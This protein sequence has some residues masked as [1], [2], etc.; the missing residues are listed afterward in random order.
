MALL[1]ELHLYGP[2]VTALPSSIGKLQHLKK[3]NLSNTSLSALPEDIGSTETPI[4]SKADAIYQLLILARYYF[5]EALVGRLPSLQKQAH[6][7][8]AK[9][10]RK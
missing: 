1:E 6:G 9:K 7:T 4:I 2:G 3:L 8:Q 10:Q 5:V